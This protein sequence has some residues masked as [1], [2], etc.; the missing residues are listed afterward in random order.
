MLTAQRRHFDSLFDAS[1]DPWGYRTRF[2][3]QRRHA[4]VLAM[5]DRSF[6]THGFE[7]GCANGVL[8]A[9]LAERCHVLLAVD[10]SQSAVALARTATAH[11]PNVTLAQADV[12]RDWPST[13]FDLVVLVDFLYYLEAADVASVCA[14]AGQSLAENG[15]LVVAHWRGQADDFLTPTCDVHRIVRESVGSE[16]DSTLCDR[17][18]LVDLWV[19][20]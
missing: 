17:D 20:P 19:Q 12:P 3:E 16:P 10:A 7:P 1:H 9:Q 4:L 15:T 14:L 18:H 5:L 13:A 6:Y 8:T 2:S 11:Y